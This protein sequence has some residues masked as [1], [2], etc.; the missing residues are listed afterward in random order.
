MLEQ[1]RHERDAA[2]AEY[3]ETGSAEAWVEF[4]EL[5]FRVA[6]MEEQASA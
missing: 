5:S 3:L 6:S 1:L 2:E 4:L